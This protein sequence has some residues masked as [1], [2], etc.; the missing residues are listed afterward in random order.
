MAA[1]EGGLRGLGLGR[2][3]ERLE[4]W[5][6]LTEQGSELHARELRAETEVNAVAER[7]VP[8]GVLTGDVESQ[9]VVEHSRVEVARIAEASPD[10]LTR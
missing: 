5:H 1:H 3:F 7:D 4:S 8:V 9:R 6:Q 10:G 2:Q